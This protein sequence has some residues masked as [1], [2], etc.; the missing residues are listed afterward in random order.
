MVF[1]NEMKAFPCCMKAEFRSLRFLANLGLRAHSEEKI[2]YEEEAN[3]TRARRTNKA[4]LSL[5]YHQFNH[6]MKGKSEAL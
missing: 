1:L 3:L 5:L 2:D 6:D 4:Y